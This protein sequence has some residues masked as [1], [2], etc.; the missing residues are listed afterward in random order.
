MA[1]SRRKPRAL[2]WGASAL[3]PGKLARGCALAFKELRMQTGHTLNFVYIIP[4]LI[5]LCL[6]LRDG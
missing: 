2:P 1:R 3:N 6:L 5:L 4:I